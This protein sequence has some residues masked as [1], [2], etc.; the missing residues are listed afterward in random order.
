MRET[1]VKERFENAFNAFFGNEQTAENSALRSSRRKTAFDS[2][3]TEKFTIR[4]KTLIKILKRAF[5]FL[6][7]VFGL[8][9]MSVAFTG[10]IILRPVPEGESH[11]TLAVFITVAAALMTFLGLGD[12]RNPKHLCIPLSVVAL[13]V[14]LGIVGSVTHGVYGFGNFINHYAIWFLPL[15]F[16]LPFGAKG[17]VDK[18]EKVN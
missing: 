7:G 14:I 18:T 4:Y 13:S 15:A 11:L 3:E 8:F 12:W 17:I 1:K 5:L 9:L 2:E 6:P 10:F 16:I